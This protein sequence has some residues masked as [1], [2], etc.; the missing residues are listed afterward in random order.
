M[1][2]GLRFKMKKWLLFILTILFLS[3]SV[4]ANDTISQGSSINTIVNP[5]L[6]ITLVT[7]VLTILGSGVV[8]AWIS[9]RLAKGKE[10]L[11]Y[12]R[13]KLEEL[14]KSIDKFTTLF[15]VTNH[16]WPKVMDGALS[17]NQGLDLQ[18]NGRKD[19]DTDFWP[20]IDMLINLYFPN[21]LSNYDNFKKKK[22]IVN[23]LY[24][25]FKNAYKIKG[26]TID[27]SKNKKEFLKALLEVD[28]AS[29]ALLD[30]VAQYAQKLND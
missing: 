3:V 29:K 6:I 2:I 17:F 22:V 23:D 9:H 19:E 14:Y 30:E 5:G 13:K 8:A 4:F 18:I 12:K 1:A 20:E 21:F 7:A 10:E 24:Q 25:E 16:M 27:Y 28:E 15:F 11:F 26:P